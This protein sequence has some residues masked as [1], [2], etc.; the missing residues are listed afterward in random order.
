M[1]KGKFLLNN[2]DKL[3]LKNNI[4]FKTLVYNELNSVDNWDERNRIKIKLHSK[5]L[6][7]GFKKLAQP[8]RLCLLGSLNGPSV[9]TTLK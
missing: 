9:S 6:E 4:E 5:K 8:L 2:N 1:N 3:F 7:I